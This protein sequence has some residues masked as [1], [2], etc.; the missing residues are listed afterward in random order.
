M[1]IVN[2]FMMRPLVIRKPREGS[3]PTI[4]GIGGK[5]LGDTVIAPGASGEVSFWDE[6]KN[7]P[8]YRNMLDRKLITVGPDKPEAVE[9]FT[10]AGDTLVAPDRFN[11]DAVKEDATAKGVKNLSYENEPK[12]AAKRRGRKPKEEGD[13]EGGDA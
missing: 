5:P 11:P 3:L 9:P 10:S 1:P 7:H 6:V 12:I 13:D 2:N 4:F 8:V